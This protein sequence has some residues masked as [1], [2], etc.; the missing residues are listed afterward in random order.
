MLLHPCLTHSGT[1]RNIAGQ[2][3]VLFYL[4]ISPIGKVECDISVKFSFFTLKV[5]GKVPELAGIR[6]K[7]QKALFH[8][9]RMNLVKFLIFRVLLHKKLH[10]RITN[11]GSQGIMNQARILRPGVLPLPTDGRVPLSSEK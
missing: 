5:T 3:D 6:T 9:E 7:F 4:E 10:Y 11:T 1:V 8:T 2:N